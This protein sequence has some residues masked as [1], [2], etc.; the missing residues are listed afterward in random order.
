MRKSLSAALLVA[1]VSGTLAVGAGTA[2]AADIE[3]HSTTGASACF[4]TLTKVLTVSDTLADG[5]TAY[6]YIQ[7]TNGN[8]YAVH[9]TGGNGTSV[10]VVLG[11]AFD[12]GGNLIWY[13][14]RVNNSGPVTETT[15]FVDSYDATA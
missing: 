11:T 9:T 12:N 15:W 3:C 5:D 10:S 1:A 2:H 8:V 14:A 7:A 6:A 4:N 13:V